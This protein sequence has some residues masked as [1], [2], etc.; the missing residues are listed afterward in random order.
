M[1]V[2]AAVAAAIAATGFCI[3]VRA[4]NLAVIISIVIIISMFVGLVVAIA[5]VVALLLPVWNMQ[6]PRVRHPIRVCS[7]LRLMPDGESFTTFRGSPR[8]Q[9]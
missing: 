5:A 3:L 4:R 7:D 2:A 8:P 1:V 6:G 9:A